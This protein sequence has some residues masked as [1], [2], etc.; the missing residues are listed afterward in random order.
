MAAARTTLTH[1]QA[2]GRRTV[3][4]G[5]P[6][7]G[8]GSAALKRRA[9]ASRAKR[10]GMAVAA[11]LAAAIAAGLVLDGIGFAGVMVTFLAIVAAAV[12]F[13]IYPK[14]K[15]P[16]RAELN[17]GDVKQLVG[18]TEIW[19]EAQRPALPPPAVD[20]VDRIGFQ[21]D[22]LGLQ[23]ETVDQA[24]PAATETRKLVGEYLPEM[25]DSYSRIPAHLRREQRAG[26]TPEVQLVEGLERISGEIDQVTRKLADGALD[27]LA[28]RSRYLEYKFA[29][30]D[31]P[32]SEPKP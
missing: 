24:H 8:K 29:G 6:S 32:G 3:R 7:I 14:V 12:V 17:R 28:I 13:S 11:I 20:L 4:A 22:E 31:G 1:Q 18:R 21:L 5:D 23:L 16:R 30:S 26:A 2:G 19:L 15:V 10:A 27:D 25:I 9:Y